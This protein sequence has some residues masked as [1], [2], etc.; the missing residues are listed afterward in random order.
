[1]ESSLA[2]RAFSLLHLDDEL[3]MLPVFSGMV[4]LI[5]LFFSAIV[6]YN[7][8]ILPMELGDSH[9]HIVLIISAIILL[10]LIIHFI[11]L[12]FNVALAANVIAYSRGK[13]PSIRHGLIIAW[14]NLET[15]LLW[16]LI[17]GTVG[18]VFQLLYNS[19]TWLAKLLARLLGGEWHI[20]SYL[21]V[22]L[23]AVEDQGVLRAVKRSDAMI[24]EKWGESLISVQG[25]KVVGI[26]SV[27]LCLIPGL[28]GIYI[29]V[30]WSV[31]VGVTLSALSLVTLLL[32]DSA[33]TTVLRCVL[34]LYAEKS[35]TIAPFDPETLQ[36]IF[37]TEA[38]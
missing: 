29:G 36:A 18:V 3:L 11:I 6:T 37:F 22:P 24:K 30:M 20:K 32:I 28:V 2:S 16:S 31:V 4:C 12:F 9:H 34:Y 35:I 17:T 14:N 25:I 8:F 26:I 7:E 23:I 21:V 1:M 38:S 19:A 13:K 27:I 5:V 15:I 10:C 33:L